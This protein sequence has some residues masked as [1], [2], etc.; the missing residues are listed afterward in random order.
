MLRFAP[1]LL[2]LTLACSEPPAYEPLLLR[3]LGGDLARSEFAQGALEPGDSVSFGDSTHGW[4]P[5]RD[6]EAGIEPAPGDPGLPRPKVLEAAGRWVH[7][8]RLEG[9]KRYVVEG[10]LVGRDLAPDAVLTLSAVDFHSEPDP[11]GSLRDMFAHLGGSRL[12]EGESE[13]RVRFEFEARPE[14]EWMALSFVFDPGSGGGQ[15]RLEDLVVRHASAAEM[16][17][18]LSGNEAAS[19]TEGTWPVGSY[20]V[21]CTNR[22][23]IALTSGG[24]A[25]L[26]LSTPEEVDQVE[27][28]VGL[29]PLGDWIGPASLH[30]RAHVVVGD[31]SATLVDTTLEAATWPEA[32]WLA[33]RGTWP[34]FARGREAELRFEVASGADQPVAAVFGDLKLSREDATADPR[35]NV[36]LISLDTLRADRMSSYGYERETTPNIDRFAERSM[37]FENTRAQA[38]YTLPSHV[39]ML[40]GQYPSVHGVNSLRNAL[41]EVRTPLLT[42]ILAERGYHTAAFTGGGFLQTQFGFDRDF[43]SFGVVD[44]VLNLESE[45]IKGRLRID[46]ALSEDLARENTIERVTRWIDEVGSE[47]FFLFV[48]TYMT[49]DF[50]APVDALAELGLEERKLEHDIEALRAV[51]L[52]GL[53]RILYPDQAIIDRLREYYDGTVRHVD[54]EIAKLLDHLD[55]ENTIVVI[56]SDHG[57]EIGERGVIGHGTTLYEELVRI[58]LIVHVPT[59]DPRRDSNPAMTVDVVPTILDALRLPALPSAQGASL[60]RAMQPRSQV[61]EVDNYVVKFAMTSPDGEKT[62][63]SQLDTGRRIESEIEWERFD[64]SVDPFERTNLGATDAL[65]ELL[66][67]TNRALLE[68][69]ETLGAGRSGEALDPQ[70]IANLRALGYLDVGN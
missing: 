47:P 36:V 12:P 31:Q 2:L 62:I 35:L 17:A 38:P 1:L 48:H 59:L 49:H 37:V 32:R 3:P 9:R 40:S 23:G 15:A 44:P 43:D 24:R 19:R 56:T 5:F 27:L 67:T 25:S 29:V 41:D 10:R 54:R 63:W 69:G 34:E 7:G 65:R 22:R 58:P 46:P 16:L 57:K 55:L 11:S 13:G 28:H 26:P 50:D 30:V 20:S 42:T 53:E 45:R 51:G 64:L 52:P 33:V 70:T 4:M 66:P 6:V 18:D 8:V 60:L 61:S 68:L 21:E 14:P 39:S